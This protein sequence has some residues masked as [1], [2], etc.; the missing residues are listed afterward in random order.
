MS[1]DDWQAWF[2]SY[3][4]KIGESFEASTGIS[5]QD[6]MNMSAS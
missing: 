6:F 5:K 4:N 1:Y 2:E 3:E